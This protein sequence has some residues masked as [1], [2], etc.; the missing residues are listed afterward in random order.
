MCGIFGY[1]G[2]NDCP[3][4]LYE[5]LRRLE[6]RGYDSAGIAAIAEKGKDI[7]LEKSKGK[8]S[9]LNLTAFRKGGKFTNGISHTRWATHGA[10]S[11]RNAHPHTV[12]KVSI[13][14]NGIIENYSL[15]RDSLV[16]DGVQLNSD[17]DSELIA[18][19][20]SSEV[21]KTGDMHKAVQNILPLL[22]GAYSV[23]AI[24]EDE[25][26]QIQ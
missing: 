8:V 17:T 7:T 5:G 23:L 18:H 13:V 4:L 22:R 25:P 19:L 15:I 14:H 24:W 6:Y 11:E 16:K 1:I 3:E 9:N 2:N 12:E 21:K 26:E 20:L 10:P